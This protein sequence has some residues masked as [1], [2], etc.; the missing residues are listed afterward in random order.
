MDKMMEA[1][2]KLEKTK[3]SFD[4]LFTAN[5]M[6]KY[7]DFT[8]ME[9]FCDAA[10]I[11]TEEDFRAMPESTLDAHVAKTTRFSNWDNMLAKAGE[12]YI[13]KQLGF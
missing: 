6:K 2:E 1:A 3:V 9:A 12:E 5:F 11:K 13:A 10:G 4:E 7:T 8:S